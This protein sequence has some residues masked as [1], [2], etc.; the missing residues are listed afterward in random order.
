MDSF[1]RRGHPVGAQ[2]AHA[3][4]RRQTVVNASNHSARSAAALVAG[5]ITVLA[6]CGTD[7]GR[8]ATNSRIPTTTSTT[9]ATS[10]P[11][12]TAAAPIQSRT[13]RWV[14]LAAGDCLADQPPTDPAVVTVTVVDCAAPHLAET[15]L[16]ADIPVDTAVTEVANQRCDA[17]FAAYTGR[18][19]GGSDMTIT[20]LIDSEQDRTSNNPYPSTV[21]CLLQSGDGQPMTGSARR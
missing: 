21:I 20:Y 1:G 13:A 18:P 10:S 17:G 6:A 2:L 4:T 8:G 14:D 3:S 11:A 5:L 9:T 19:V 15:F 16:R 7:A 12:I